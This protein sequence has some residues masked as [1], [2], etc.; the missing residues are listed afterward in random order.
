MEVSSTF[1]K[2]TFSRPEKCHCNKL[3]RKPNRQLL[4]IPQQLQLLVS[5]H[6]EPVL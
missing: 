5:S 4:A 3:A 6:L 1:Y 2:Y